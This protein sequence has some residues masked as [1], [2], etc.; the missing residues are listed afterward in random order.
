MFEKF[1]TGKGIDVSKQHVISEARHEY[2]EPSQLYLLRN[3]VGVEAFDYLYGVDIINETKYFRILLYEWFLLIK[4]GGYLITEFEDNEVLDHAT[5]RKEIE[6]LHLYKN[7][8]EIVEDGKKDWRR[9]VVVRKT[10]SVKVDEDQINQWTFGIVT[11]G[12][13]K[14]FIERAI[15]SIRELGIPHYQIILCGTYNGEIAEDMEYIYFTEHDDKGWITRKKNLICQNAKYE[16]IVVIHDRIS[17]DSSWFDGMKKWGPYFDVL[18]CPIYYPNEKILRY[19]WDTM[20]FYGSKDRLNRLRS[21]SGS[22]DPT[23]WDRYVFIGG[24]IIILKK[25]IW[26]LQKW[27]EDL[28]WGDSEDVELSHKQHEKGIMIRFNP[29]SI[30][31]SSI[32]TVALMGWHYEKDKRKLGRYRMNPVLS[33]LLQTLDLLGLRRDSKVIRYAANIFNE[34]YKTRNWTKEDRN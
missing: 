23:D 19:N 10:K 33:I 17:F 26:E 6:S 29:Y 30:V 14:D 9:Y 22:L 3:D 15:N 11:N 31:N 16:N 2:V 7:N 28:F 24:P 32:V 4:E 18:S 27:N 1:T 34:L 5:L 8:S 20:G 21:T 12:K 25:H 13:R